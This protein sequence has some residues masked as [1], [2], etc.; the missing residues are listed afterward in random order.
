MD[1]ERTGAQAPTVIGLGELI[2]DLLPTGRELGGAPSN[3]AHFARLLGNSATVASRVGK[4]ALGREARERLVRA[5]LSAEYLQ[6]DR[7]HPTGTVGVEVGAGG[8]P[9]FKVN[10]NSAWDYLE[11]TPDWER[12]AANAGAVCFGTLG[13]RR[14]QA[15]STILRFLELTR[16]D[17]I[18]I[19][20]VNLRHSFFSSEMLGRSLKL[21][22]VVKLNREELGLAAGMLGL[23]RSGEAELCRELISAFGLRLVALTKGAQGSLLVTSGEAIEH[24][25]YRVPVIDTIGCGDAFAATLTHCLLTGAPLAA[26]SEAANRA[27]AWVAARR[28]ATPPADSSTVADILGPLRFSG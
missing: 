21:S 3:F 22:N 5:G 28:G 13:Q 6:V 9:H 23:R 18:R 1:P 19:F 4:D 20:D 24:A 16:P 2:W 10:E 8:E 15:R 11:L 7:E 12:L 26:A 27:G 17:A 25:G 14:A